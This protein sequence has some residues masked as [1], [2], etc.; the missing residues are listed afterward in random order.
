MIFSSL[1]FFFIVGLHLTEQNDI[2]ITEW[3]FYLK[4]DFFFKDDWY[5]I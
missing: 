3:K 5:L 2:L 4:T 1:F